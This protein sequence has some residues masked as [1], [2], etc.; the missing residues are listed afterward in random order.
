[1]PV[2]PANAEP[3]LPVWLR[4]RVEDLA[5]AVRPGFSGP[6]RPASVTRRERGEAEDA[7]AEDE[8]DQHRHL[9]LECLDLLAEVLGRAADHQAGDEDRQDRAD[10]EHPVQAGADRRPG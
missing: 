6:A 2:R 4:E 9:H 3:L 10:H 5:E 1:M 8:D 7:G